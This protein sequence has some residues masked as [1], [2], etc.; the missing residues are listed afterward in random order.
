MIVAPGIAHCGD[1]TGPLWEAVRTKSK[2]CPVSWRDAAAAK[3]FL[4][5]LFL[6][7]FD[8]NC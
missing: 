1:H 5:G 2:D 4:A 3:E 6:Q 8:H 7:Y